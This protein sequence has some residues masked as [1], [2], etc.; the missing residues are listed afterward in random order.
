MKAAVTH[1]MA[2]VS[3]S[4]HRSEAVQAQYMKQFCETVKECERL[5]KAKGQA[6]L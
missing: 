2:L 5:L 6:R 3:G 1:T 4:A